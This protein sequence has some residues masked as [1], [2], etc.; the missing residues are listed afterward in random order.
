[1]NMDDANPNIHKPSPIPSPS[2]YYSVEIVRLSIS[3]TIF[4]PVIDRAE[5]RQ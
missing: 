5:R 2:V 3:T 1:M 4:S